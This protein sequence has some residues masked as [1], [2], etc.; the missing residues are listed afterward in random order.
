MTR[1]TSY[2]LAALLLCWTQGTAMPSSGAAAADVAVPLSPSPYVADLQEVQRIALRDNPSL[3]AGAERVAQVRQWVR[4]ARSMY[5]PQVDA[6]YRYTFSWLPDSYQESTSAYLDE[7]ERV[8]RD[9][10]RNMYY[11]FVR[12]GMPSLGQRRNLRTW[13]NST[14]DFIEYMRE[15][16]D[17]PLQNATLSITAGL[18]LFDGFAREYTN[19]MARYGHQEA[20]AGLRDGQ[21]LLLDAVAQAYFGVQLAQAQMAVAESDLSFNNRL[22]HEVKTR[23]DAGRAATSDLLNFETARYA[24]RGVVL[25]AGR[26]LGA[27]RTALAVLIGMPDGKLPD[28]MAIAELEQESGATMTLPDANAMI[29]LAQSNR[30]D[31]EQ[32]DHAVKRT[33]S[34]VKRQTAQYA[35][36]I[37]AFATTQTANVNETGISTDQIS[38][39]V[40]VN[41]SLT[42]Y[43]GGRR[44][45]DI[46]EARH[47]HREAEFR[48]KE[49]EQRIAGEVQQALLDLDTAQQA[50]RLQR[51]AAECVSK[52]RELTE[53]EYRA[54]KGML[55]RLNQAQRDL[56]QAEGFLALSLVNLQRSWQALYT[57]TGTNLSRL[58]SKPQSESAL[59]STSAENPT[60]Q[61]PP[62]STENPEGTTNVTA[63][64]AINTVDE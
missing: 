16:L 35:P 31:L 38:S 21:R 57:A 37:A 42:L 18:L 45:A 2:A 64:E 33:Q 28:A 52:N 23:R 12:T 47:A 61:D 63:I 39:T 41:A 48:R 53:K 58:S 9:L 27:A 13:I 25:R 40:G 49:T 30:P 17:D 36:Q 29:A 11:S 4:K 60:G 14:E 51:A 32:R 7:S 6:T 24:A 55:V 5:L 43:A 62:L 20:Q 19:A 59:D 15:Q 56:V 44:R 50:V 46:I 1:L 8:L 10:K 34:D 22:Y 26:D 3:A 54:G